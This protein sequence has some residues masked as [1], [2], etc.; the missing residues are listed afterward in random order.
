M[1]SE[2]IGEIRSNMTNINLEHVRA[3]VAVS[4]C[5]G[6]N[7]AA[8]ML[9]KSPSTVS[10]A[11]ASLQQKLRSRLFEQRGRKLHLTE[12]GRVLLK[13]SRVL[14]AEKETLLSLAEH[15]QQAYRAEISL[16]VDAICPHTIVL[17]ALA[18]FSRQFPHCHIKLHEGVLSGAEEQLLQGQADICIA[19]RIPEG[20][21]GQRFIDID[22][23]PV[24]S[25]HHPLATETHI[26]SRQL[27]TQ[28]QVVISD[29]GRESSVNSGW[30]K[31]VSRWSV[32][33]MYTAIDII[34][35]GM[36]FGWIPKHL[37]EQDL[38]RGCLQRLDLNFGGEKSGALFITLAAE[39]CMMSRALADCLIARANQARNPELDRP[40]S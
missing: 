1:N 5:D 28:R 25:S 11:L 13:Q 29:T 8:Q 31:A 18:E 12:Q 24:V 4:E 40:I 17:E 20:F 36:A 34:K 30:L 19:Y 15:M 27:A 23:V 32:S 16:T 39:E 22:F 21:L 33:S 9:H 7:A 14:L 10:H 6:V 37:I 3:F 38:H 26:T 35:S 2:I